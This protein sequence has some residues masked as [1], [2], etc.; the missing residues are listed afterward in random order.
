MAIATNQITTVY[1]MDSVVTEV[2]SDGLPLYDRAYN[3]SDLRTF[4]SLFVTDGVSD[5]CTYLYCCVVSACRADGVEFGM[6]LTE[7]ADNLSPADLQAW[8]TALAD[9]DGGAGEDADSEKK[10]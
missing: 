2:D 3:A 9:A 6:G 10:A 8:S 7:F 5:L 4:M 1:P